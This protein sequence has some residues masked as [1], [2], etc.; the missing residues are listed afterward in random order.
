[1]NTLFALPFFFEFDFL[2][3]QFLFNYFKVLKYFISLIMSQI[4]SP[5]ESQKLILHKNLVQESSLINKEKLLMPWFELRLIV[6]VLDID[7]LLEDY[8]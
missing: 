4:M 1:M 3:S 7:S 5:K 8:Q 6:L 2:F